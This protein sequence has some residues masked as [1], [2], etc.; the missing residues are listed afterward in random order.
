CGAAA[1]GAY[2]PHCGQETR[3]RLP[4]LREFLR[5]AAGRYVAFDGRFWRTV[6]ALL[7]HP[8]FLTREYLD[9]RRRRYIRPA[10]MYLF[11]TLIF[12][13][14]SRFS[15]GPIDLADVHPDNADEAKVLS[16]DKG[17][18]LQIAPG[19]SIAPQAL[20]ERWNRFNNL[21]R[22]DKAEQLRDGM[23]RYAPYAMFALLPAIAM[24]LKLLYLGGGRRHPRRPRLFGA[25]L[26]FAAHNH[27][28]VFVAATAMLLVRALP[29]TAIGCWIVAY[30]FWS[31]HAVY[32]GSWAGV[33]ARG[34]VI[35]TLY[36]A[37]L[38][39]ATALLL[40]VAIL[41]R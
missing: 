26:V 16:A 15:V 8:G 41:L 37:L 11:A 39:V 21:G 27:A 34:C 30:L 3:L 17:F 13:A 7:L 10:R 36:A 9:G 2:C 38:A 18:N 22:Q 28:F 6:A 23:L 1:G 31:L 29:A 4:T 12:F 14:V 25:H 35:A 20:Q 19:Q 24:L 5:E 32:E 33:V 40:M